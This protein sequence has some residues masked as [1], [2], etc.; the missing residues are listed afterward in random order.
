[1][2]RNQTVICGKIIKLGTLRYTPAGVAVI[3]FTINHSSRQI[4]AGITRQVLCE[5]F[6]VALGQMAITI[7]N[8]KLNTMVNLTGF[9]NR[10]SRLNQQLVLHVDNIVQI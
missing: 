6:A 5:I 9:L 7:S 4:E 8:F 3:D 10:K 1:M 2:D